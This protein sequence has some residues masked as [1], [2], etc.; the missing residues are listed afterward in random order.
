MAIILNYQEISTRMKFDN[1]PLFAIPDLVPE[2]HISQLRKTVSTSLKSI[3]RSF[4]I[5]LKSTDLFQTV[6]ITVRSC[7]RYG[8]TGHT[9]ENYLSCLTAFL[10]MATS[11]HPSSITQIKSI[12][13]IR[14]M[15]TGTLRTRGISCI[16][17]QSLRRCCTN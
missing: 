16:P 10:R 8:L 7:F 3:N 9:C 14:S 4:G 11:R 6:S 15:L 1:K 2:E 5:R 17:T 12:T 13:P